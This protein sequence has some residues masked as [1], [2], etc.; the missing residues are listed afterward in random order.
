M[1]K[2]HGMK[3]ISPLRVLVAWFLGVVLTTVV[4]A[5]SGPVPPSV[6]KPKNV[7]F[8][9]VDDLRPKLGCYGDPVAISPNIDS[10]AKESTLFT[11]AYDQY[12]VCGPSRAS[13]LSGLRPDSTGIYGNDIEPSKA[14][15]NTLVIN[16]Y[17]AK[18]GFEVAGFGKV[19][20]DGDGPKEAAWTRPFVQSKWLDY[21]RPENR[22]IGDLWFTPKHK[23]GERIPSSWEAEDVPD[24][25]YGDGMVAREAVKTLKEFAGQKKPFMM[26][27]GFR[28]PHLPW[29]APKKY[30]DLYDRSKLP[31]A[32][33]R[34]FPKDAPEVSLNRFGELWSY[35]N[36]PQGVPLTEELQKQA[37]HGYYACMSYADAQVGKIIAELKE[38]RLYDDTV[39]VLVSD[40]GYQMGDNGTWCKEVNWEATNHIVLLLRAPGNGKPGQ[41]VEHLVELLDVYPTLCAASGVPIPAHCEGGSL[42]PLMDD[43]KTPWTDVVFNQFKRGNVMGRS[44]RTERYRFTLWEDEG[45]KLAGREL[46]DQQED[47]QG[48]V[49][50]ADHPDQKGRVEELTMLLRE[51]WP[52]SHLAAETADT[53]KKAHEAKDAPPKE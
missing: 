8:V 9:I 50:L 47:P 33:N 22:A 7:V 28:H 17:F 12:P 43:P 2:P 35:A 5:A 1:S 14:L 27:V 26:I 32:T 52:K 44:L 20:H 36:T 18:I 19:Y 40:N 30:W 48:N 16:R 49:N 21:V 4:H 37:V 15:A 24:D 45:G 31:T 25:S 13:F 38:L 46:Y 34:D 53:I 11:R 41:V 23:K 10:L 51:K 29:C 3:R 42:L 39:I 6:T